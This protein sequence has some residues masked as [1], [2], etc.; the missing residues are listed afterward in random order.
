MNPCGEMLYFLDSDDLIPSNAF[1][2]LLTSIFKSGADFAV[3]AY[4]RVGS[5]NWFK[6][7]WVQDHHS[8]SDTMYPFKIIRRPKKIA[9]MCTKSFHRNFF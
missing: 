7:R 5:S 6:L 3:G 8:I 1:E 2:L 9:L 4:E